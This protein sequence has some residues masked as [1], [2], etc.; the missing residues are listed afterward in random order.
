MSTHKATLEFDLTDPEARSAFKRTCAAE[1]LTFAL[2]EFQR[3]LRNQT[4]HG[5]PPDDIDAVQQAFFSILDGRGIDLEG[6]L[7]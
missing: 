7:T 5:D 1:D 4:K 2:L 3:Y 6:L